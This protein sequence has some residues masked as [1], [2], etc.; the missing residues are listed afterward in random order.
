MGQSCTE[1]NM[2]FISPSEL[3]DSITNCNSFSPS[4]YHA[5]VYMHARKHAYIHRVIELMYARAC[6]STQNNQY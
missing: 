3:V 1:L 2:S 5:Y 6:M 4:I